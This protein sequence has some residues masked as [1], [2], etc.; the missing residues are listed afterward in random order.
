MRYKNKYKYYGYVYLISTENYSKNNIYK[1]GCTKNLCKRLKDLNASRIAIDQFKIFHF[2]RTLSYYQLEANAHKLFKIFKLNNEFY[3]LYKE[4][5]INGI[6]NLNL[7]LGVE[8]THYDIIYSFI[9]DNNICWNEMLNVFIINHDMKA[10]EDQMIYFIKDIIS[11]NDKYNLYKF[12][13][14]KYYLQL[15]NFLKKKSTNIHSENNHVI[16]NLLDITHKLNNI[17]IV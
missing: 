6:N 17:S 7:N 10:E 3:Q 16:T 13:S 5:I 9:E 11:V 15:L 1:I 4:E 12:I 14:E 2:W 8:P